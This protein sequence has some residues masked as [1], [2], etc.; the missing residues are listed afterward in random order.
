MSSWLGAVISAAVSTV[1]IISNMI[2]SK[3]QRDAN[4]NLQRET[5]SQNLMLARE[6][7]EW[8]EKMIEEYNDY[9]SPENQRKLLEDAGYNPVLFS[10]NGMTQN[11]LPSSANLANQVAPQSHM[12][13]SG[14]NQH[15]SEIANSGLT[16]LQA[17]AI[18]AQTDKTV[19]ESSQIQAM[20]KQIMSQT[21]CN[22]EQARLIA[23]NVDKANEEIKLIRETIVSTRLGQNKTLQ[24]IAESKNRIDISRKQLLLQEKLTRAE[25][26]K[27]FSDIGL[28]DARISEISQQII[29]IGREAVKIG[30]EISILDIQ[31]II[32]DIE[33]DYKESEVRANLDKYQ[34]EIYDKLSSQIYKTVQ[35]FTRDFTSNVS[36][37]L[38]YGYQSR[39]GDYGSQL[40]DRLNNQGGYFNKQY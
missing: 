26:S 12:E 19:K 27:L 14:F 17:K 36:N 31:K 24:D 34:A 33:A 23:V 3:K 21:K 30:R 7:N 35:A 18:E 15:L 8:T 37:G 39:F 13:M 16:Y 1:G 10:P 25:I 9:N 28:N 40:Y 20:T 6:Q 4:V 2:Q 5:N 22:E 29:K 11:T 32:Y 38:G